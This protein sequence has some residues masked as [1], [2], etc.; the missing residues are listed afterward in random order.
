MVL[1]QCRER[2]DEKRQ[3]LLRTVR[4]AVQTAF[5]VEAQIHGVAPHALPRT[6]SGKLSRAKAKQLFL[7]RDPSLELALGTAS[8]TP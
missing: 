7:D 3:A 6:T 8:E 1:L 4:R 5:G 2:D